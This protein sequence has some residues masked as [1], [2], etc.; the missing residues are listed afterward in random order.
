V[1]YKIF[2][3]S[4]TSD[5]DEEASSRT[6]SVQKVSGAIVISGLCISGSGLIMAKRQCWGPD[7]RQ[8]HREETNTVENTSNQDNQV[9]IEEVQCE[10]RELGEIHRENA[11]QGGNRT[12]QQREAHET[13]RLVRTFITSTGEHHEEPCD[14]H[15]ELHTLTHTH[16]DVNHTHT[17][18]F[19]TEPPQ[20]PKYFRSDHGNHA[21]EDED[22]D[23]VEQDGHQT[24]D[25]GNSDVAQV[26]TQIF[27]HVQ[28][29]LVQVVHEPSWETS[30]RRRVRDITCTL[31]VT[32][33]IR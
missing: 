25:H 24:Q 7:E 29:L 21:R 3:V 26:R 19:Q 10:V 8:H 32:D 17:I 6:A 14:V 18:E 30:H 28:V 4:A 11:N 31:N 13:K 27:T 1:V 12:V 15:S 33:D 20:E 9:L 2:V 22:S 16:D 5:F 23:G